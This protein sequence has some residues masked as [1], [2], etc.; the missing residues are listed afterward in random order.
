[1]AKY[2]VLLVDDEVEVRECLQ[3]IAQNFDL[4]FTHA[5]DGDEGLKLIL[6]QDFDCVV[7]DVKMP[8]MTGL[9]MLMAARAKGRDVPMVFISAF[10]NNELCHDLSNYG[11][12]KLLHK[13]DILQARERIQEAIDWGQELRSIHKSHDAI[14]ED[15]IQILHGTK[16]VK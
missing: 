7:S 6:A 10:A 13:L 4:E 12:V 9:E 16:G 5:T 14:G 1:M 2:K 8:R 15:F 3:G 11:A